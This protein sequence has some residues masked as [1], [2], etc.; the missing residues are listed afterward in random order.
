[1][2]P[3]RH[4]E[5]CAR[6]AVAGCRCEPASSARLKGEVRSVAASAG[7]GW[8]LPELS[9]LPSRVLPQAG[10]W[11]RGWLAFAGHR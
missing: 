9:R 10:P 4:D 1:M 3:H 11:C 2:R 5:A 7:L 6:T 8:P